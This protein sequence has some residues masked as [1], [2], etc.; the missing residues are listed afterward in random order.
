MRITQKDEFK[1]AIVAQLMIIY[2]S[3]TQEFI[4]ESLRKYYR[5]EI[6]KY[7]YYH[8]LL[9]IKIL[10]LMIFI[11]C[12]LA[13]LC[14]GFNI[15]NILITLFLPSIYYFWMRN[16]NIKFWCYSLLDKRLK[17]RLEKNKSFKGEELY[18]C[19]ANETIEILEFLK[20]NLTF[21]RAKFML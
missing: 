20:N 17:Q 1:A 15:F 7:E 4:L 5:D 2:S 18:E 16:Q 12:F 6:W 21:E 14:H 19:V 10:S 3:D 9:E 11:L 8:S 13:A